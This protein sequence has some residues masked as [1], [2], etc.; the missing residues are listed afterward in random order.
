MAV[1][2]RARIYWPHAIAGVVVLLLATWNNFA[3]TADGYTAVV[4][5][6]LTLSIVTVLAMLMTGWLG[7]GR[8]IHV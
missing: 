4:P 5:Y 6:G 7:S 2:T 3:H 8:I 1:V